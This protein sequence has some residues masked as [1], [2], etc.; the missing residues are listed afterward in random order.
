M[1]LSCICLDTDAQTRVLTV[2]LDRRDNEKN[3]FNSALIEE[4]QAVL[5]AEL[6]HPQY[7]GLILRSSREKVFSTGADIEGQLA[8]IEPVDAGHFSRHGREV[9]GLLSRL[10][11]ITVAAVSG[12]ALGGGWRSACAATSASP[13][14]ARAW[15]CPKSTSG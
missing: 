5:A 2:T 12:F 3:Q 8:G 10:P 14:R 7:R 1:E 15:A 9:F 11:Y 4:L 6:M 13:P